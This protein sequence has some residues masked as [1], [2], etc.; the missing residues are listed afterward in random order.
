MRNDL[1]MCP[2][3]GSLEF[4][5]SDRYGISLETG[6]P[7]MITVT[8]SCTECGLTLTRGQIL[9]L[10]EGRQQVAVAAG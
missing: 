1:L 7:V 2:E 9:E 5:G 6:Y 8:Y 4:E 10:S 3:C